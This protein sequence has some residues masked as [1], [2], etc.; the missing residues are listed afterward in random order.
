MYEFSEGYKFISRQL[1]EMKGLDT[2]V[3]KIKE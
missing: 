1:E 2:R 3:I